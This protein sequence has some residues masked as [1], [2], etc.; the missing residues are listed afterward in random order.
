[1]PALTSTP[2]LIAAAITLGILVGFSLVRLRARYGETERTYLIYG[3]PALGVTV[4]V[5]LVDIH[6]RSMLNLTSFYLI[7]L[8]STPI[9]IKRLM[10]N[11][12]P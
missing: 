3:V 9:I 12:K 2:V 1:M 7:A 10:K 8:F 4:A 11:R 5:A 6:R